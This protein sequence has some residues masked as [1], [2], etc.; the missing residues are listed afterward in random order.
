MR[1]DGSTPIPT[2]KKGSCGCSN[3]KALVVFSGLCFVGLAAVWGFAGCL[4]SA[5]ENG[6]R[7]LC[8]VG[9]FHFSKYAVVLAQFS[10]VHTSSLLIQGALALTTSLGATCK[11]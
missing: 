7:I 6:L 3:Y 4:D 9:L 8:E 10:F 1:R 5:F 2:H 11:G